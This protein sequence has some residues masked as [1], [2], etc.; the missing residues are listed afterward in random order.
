MDDETWDIRYL[1]VAT[2]NWWPGKTVLVSPA[3]IQRV[4]WED[5]RL[6]AGLSREAIRNAPEYFEAVRITLEYED[7]LLIHYG[8]PPYWLH[9]AAHRSGLSSG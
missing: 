4:N 2:R 6:Y 8:Q 1:E 7:R 3:W 5:S 9:D